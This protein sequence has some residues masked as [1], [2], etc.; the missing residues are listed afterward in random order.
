MTIFNA[1]VLLI[2]IIALS[3]M[4]IPEVDEKW[5]TECLKN[6]SLY[7]EYIDNLDDC[8]DFINTWAIITLVLC[9]LIG[10]FISAL[11]TRMLYYGWK[12]QEAHHNQQ[13]R[14]VDPNDPEQ[15]LPQ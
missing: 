15:N 8:I 1:I 2:A 11:L 6:D 12:E 5:K 13:Y 3:V 4:D 9:L 7:P 14:Q 10:S